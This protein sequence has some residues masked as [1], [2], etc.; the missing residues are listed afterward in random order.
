[1]ASKEDS[2]KATPQTRGKQAVVVG[3]TAGIG[4]GI[5]VRLARAGCNVTIVGRSEK[6]GASV[7]SEMRSAYAEEC[8]KEENRAADDSSPS[9]VFLECDCF[10]LSNVFDC[11]EKLRKMHSQIDYLV[12][13]QGMATFQGFTPSKEEGLDQKLMLH[14][15]SR[16]AFARG[17]AG[18]LAASDDGRFLSM[19]SAGVH[20]P[21]RNYADDPELSLGGYSIKNAADFAGFYNDII[22]D[23]FS[24]QFDGVSFMH[25]CPGFVAT[26]WG[27]E[28]P[29]PVRWI[30]RCMQCCCGRSRTKCGDYMY[31]ALTNP[32]YARSAHE[33]AHGQ[34]KSFF[35]IDE[36]GRH[37][38]KTT[39]LHEEAKSQVATN[40][41]AVLEAGKAVAA[42]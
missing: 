21:F 31:R 25:A 22:V 27:T 6:R 30:I 36:Y 41:T 35:L 9:Y 10:L 14:V 37:T 4:R 3:A 18:E 7:I 12:C 17:L 1:M 16:A 11:I 28:M 5:S 39:K 20:S 2:E 13:S 40:V 23:E 33:G 34:G 8:E 38:Q 26:A 24:R 15:Y 19:L 42:K 32:E 29:F